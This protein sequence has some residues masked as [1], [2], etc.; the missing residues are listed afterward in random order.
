MKVLVIAS[1]RPEVIKLSP[2]L[3]ELQ[4]RGI[5]HVFATTGQHYD[6]LLFKKFIE[7]LDLEEPCYNIEVGSA[8]QA[9]QTGKAMMGIEEM[10]M[11]ESPDVLV[12][13]GD[14]NSV[15]GS[16]LAAVKLKIPVAHVEAGLRSLDRTMPEEI[17]RILVDH[18]SEVLFAPTENS[19]LNLV[20]EGIPPTKIHIVGNTIVDATLSNLEIAEKTSKVLEKVPKH[21]VLL[22]LHRQENTD[23]LERLEGIFSAIKE[24]KRN[25]VFP[26]HPR[27]SK[28]IENTPLEKLL[29]D[30]NIHV[31]PPLGYLDF[32]V[33]LKN[34]F[35]VLTDSG[36]VQEEAIILNIPCLTLRYNTERPE[37]VWAGGN[38]IAGTKK[39]EIL[40]KVAL[41]G[42]PEVYQ[43]MKDAVNPFGDGTAGERIVNILLERYTNGELVVESSDT[44]DGFYSRVLLPVD[45]KMAGMKLKDAGYD[46]VKIIDDERERFPFP[47]S[48]LK[49]G[50]YVEVLRKG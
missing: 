30:K 37:S 39:E 27:T 5:E 3:R 41:L 43:K 32:L 14:T 1:T 18:C 46:I 48:V 8:T 22:T 23:S 33:L 28:I 50:Q 31:I 9:V 40:D 19:A 12:V 26:I 36:G 24:M 7:D 44:R 38:I 2:V 10:L 16:A 13:E 11:K 21:Y 29:T 35:A 17:N 34:A 25:I 45:G 4:A 6:A 20:N 15:L 49:K 47:D 42:G